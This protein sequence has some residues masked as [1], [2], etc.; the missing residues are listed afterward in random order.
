MKGSLPLEKRAPKT[1]NH[2][3]HHTDPSKPRLL[4]HGCHVIHC[5]HYSIRPEQAYAETRRDG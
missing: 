5:K 2:T 3:S 1:S 4:N